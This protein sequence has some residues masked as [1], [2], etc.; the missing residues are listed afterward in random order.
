MRHINNSFKLF[1]LDWQRVFKNPIATLLIIALLIIPSL[2]AWFNIGALWDPYGNTSELPIAIYSDDQTVSLKEKKINIG[3]EVL[4]NLHK[5]KQLGWRFVDSKKVLDDGV[6]S[7]KYY[8]GIYLPREFSKDLMSFVSGDIKNQKLN[9]QL[10]KKSMPLRQRLQLR[11]LLL[12]RSRLQ[13]NLS[14]QLVI[15][16]YI[17][18][19]KLVTMLIQI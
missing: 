15:L 16:Y 3:D 6:K 8:A 9:I 1:K 7:R 12:Y 17:H 18:S 13:I 2:Y 19:T 11:G 10:M 4:K 14:K 5:N